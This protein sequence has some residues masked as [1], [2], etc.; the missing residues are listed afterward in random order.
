[1]I[2]NINLILK[3]KIFTLIFLITINS[4]SYSIENKIIFKIDNN[5]ITNIDV[6]NEVIYLKT[7]NPN[8]RDLSAEKIYEIAKNSLI[9]ENIKKIEIKKNQLNAI[10]QE[11]LENIVENIYKNIGLSSK[12]EFINYLKTSNID[13]QTIEKK[14]EVE[15]QWNGLIFNKFRSKIKI[16]KLKI[17]EEIKSSKSVNSY[18]LY[19]ILFDA[20]NNMNAKEKFNQIIKS[21][22]ENGVENTASIFSLSDSSKTGG[23]LGW[24][25][26][27]SLSK[28][29]S[30]ELKNIKA[31][32]TT[33]PIL[34][35]GGFLIL[36]VKDIKKIEEEIDFDKEYSQRI[37]SLQNLQLNQYSNIYFNK[38]KKNLTIYE[39]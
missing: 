22:D 32:Q 5:I 39:E 38:I 1:M 23:K 16:D 31:K 19:E 21:I 13:L 4:F 26:E 28:K 9:R 11:Y 37:R 30:N 2:K 18:F 20:K 24:I 35:P 34:I 6:D 29:I 12:Q 15:A 33:K 7:L 25:K 8:L 36:Y 10:N 3:I 14:L 17:S 27:S